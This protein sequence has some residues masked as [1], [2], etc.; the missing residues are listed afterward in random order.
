MDHDDFD[1]EPIRGLPRMLPDGER[2]L[3]QGAPSARALARDA[4]RW[5]WVAGYFAV[6]FLWS[7]VAGMATD[8]AAAALGR[9]SFYA[10]AG[11]VA[12]ALLFAVAWAQARATVYTITTRR[13]VMRIGAA[14][15]MTLQFPYRW[16]GAA[17]L[18]LAGDG[19]GTIALR[20][21][22]DTRFSYLMT[23]PHARPWRFRKTQPALRCIPDAA[24]VARLMAEAAAG[25]TALTVTEA[26]A[27][28]PVAAQPMPAE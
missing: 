7:F 1:Q 4:L 18:Q 23:W 21:L 11:A 12:C 16:I 3:W 15:T 22:G 26:P 8:S 2:I 28:A 17:D 5:R 14:L 27:R 24:A 25:E 20:T 19:T 9:A 10:A 13:V 6:L